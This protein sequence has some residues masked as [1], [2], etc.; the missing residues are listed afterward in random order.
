MSNCVLG[1]DALYETGAVTVDG[2]GIIRM[3]KAESLGTLPEGA[4][5]EL[6]STS[7]VLLNQKCHAFSSKTKGYFAW[8]FDKNG[9][10]YG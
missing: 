10:E 7:P 5:L 1:C 3:G 8:H 2:H 9:V 6:F 4:F